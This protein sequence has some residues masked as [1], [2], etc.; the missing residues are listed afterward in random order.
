MRS[1]SLAPLCA[2]A[3][4]G[5]GC[6]SGQ[7]EPSATTSRPDVQ[8]M[9]EYVRSEG[10]PGVVWLVH[11]Q[12]GTWR[13]ATGAAVLK[14]RRKMRPGER[15]RVASVTKTFVATLV[16]QLVGEGRLGLNDSVERRLPGVLRQGRRITLR[17]LL[18]HTS[19]LYDY[20][21]DMRAQARLV[22]DVRPLET[23]AIAA[24][25]PLRFAPGTSWAYSNSGYQVL[26]LM[27]ERA[28]GKPLGQVLARR[29]FAPLDLRHTSF[30]PPPRLPGQV[31]HGYTSP[32]G[33]IPHA[34]DRPRD[35]THMADDGTWADGAI[36]S[37]VDDLARF[38]S[39]LLR[40]KVLRRGLLHE[41][42]R[43]VPID[44]GAWAGLGLLRTRTPCGFAWG[45]DGNMPGYLTLVLASKDGSRLV[46][47]AANG[48][49]R[50]VGSALD[51]SARNAYCAS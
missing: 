42:Q 14:P 26:G 11:N 34:G 41:M 13:G 37:N 21:D 44:F 17:Q 35:V 43:T 27:I 40:G 29:I 48:D 23:V 8:R 6:S 20:L 31:A 46:V 49:G 19:G 47:M 32:G 2:F 15:F 10:A 39:A 50:R 51:A 12:P 45:H 28:T 4:L 16:L 5:G 30:E 7:A 22:G 3:V 24:S 1:R 38:Y 18:N 33:Q 9:V 25:R 36:V